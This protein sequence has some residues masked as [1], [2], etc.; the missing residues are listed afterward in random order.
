MI[1]EMI[2]D[3]CGRPIAIDIETTPCESEVSRVAALRVERAS[4]VGKLKAARRVKAPRAEIEALA[5]A[6]KTLN[7]RIKHAE[8][9][10]LDPHRSHI[11]LLQ[12]YGG[13]DR[14]AVIDLFR[15]GPDVLRKLD[16]VGVVA[17]NAA[18]ELAH[19]EHA[20]V[21]LGEVHCTMQAVRL[22]L[23][24]QAMCLADAAEAYLGV[25]LGKAEQTSE[26][27]QARLTLPQLRYAADDVIACWGIARRL[28]PA[29]GSQE[30]AY[31][32]QIAATAAVA[33]MELRG[34][35]LNIDA[36]AKLIDDLK[37]ERED[38]CAAYA[39]ACRAHGR[40]DL[41]TAPPPA[42]PHEKESLLESLLTSAELARW[43]RT[44]KSGALSTRRSDMRRAAHYPPIAALVKLAAIDKL[45]SAFGPTLAAVVSPVTGRIHAH[46][47]VAATASGRATCS[48][49][50]LQQMP[51]DKRFRALFKPAPGN[52]LVSGDFSS[53]EL[54]AAAHISGDPVMTH[55]FEEGQ[56]LHRITASKMS[57]K[58]LEDVTDGERRAAKAINFGAIYGI[59]ARGL[60]KS[61]WDG[62]G[63][64][65][66]ERE[67]ATWLEAF[68]SAYPT[69]VRWRWEHARKCEEELRIVIG[70]DAAR[71][72]G[73]FFPKSRLKPDR[74]YYT[75]SCNLP[76]Q[77]ACADASML[78]LKAIDETLF[79]ARIVGGPVAW[80]H[81]EIVLE[82][83][84]NDAKQAAELLERAMVSG[85]AET[86]PGAPTRGLVEPHT[87]LS[88]GEAKG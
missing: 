15:T 21:A 88:W 14:V 54:R 24:E 39:E 48:G 5:V 76:I 85:F 35:G 56:D 70:K 65:I 40:E 68:A 6:V 73:R 43:Q 60:M 2:A 55:A 74:S 45:L 49:P 29:L 3:L 77:G 84:A 46:Y 22:T 7:A 62:Y 20:G 11:R 27:G 38:A 51:R 25:T 32:V 34:F 53:M 79:D 26:W 71:G 57:G 31:E 17:H 69:F 30:P 50:N 58:S 36:H 64:R 1:D 66:S 63:L 8:A 42:T 82:V 59:G 41:A 47:R 10:G 13:G 61:A 75:R 4:A 44:E 52:V 67:A 78:A 86:F 19:L 37:R 16:G 81:D 72:R 33:R 18:F 87:G 28:F 12:V 9:A 23:G 83:P 80:L